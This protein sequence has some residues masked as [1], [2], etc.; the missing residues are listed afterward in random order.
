MGSIGLREWIIIAFII[1]LIFGSKRLPELA[2]SIGKAL[3]EFRKGMRD[4]QDELQKGEEPGEEK[5]EG[6]ESS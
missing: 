5:K 6:N 2:R 3:S 4:V 1:L